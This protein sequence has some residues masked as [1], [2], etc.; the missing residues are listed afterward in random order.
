MEYGVPAFISPPELFGS[1]TITWILLGLFVYWAGV[2]ALRNANLLPSYVGTQGP[3]L[4]FHTKRGRAFLD[5][6]SGPKRFW[7]A[8]ANFG[9]G[10]SLVVMVAMFGFL[11]LAAIAALTS[12]QPATDVQQP[13]NVLVIPGV[14]DFLPLSAAPGI[15]FGLLVGLVVHEG[16][17]GLLCRVE[18]ID[19]NSMGVAM[20]AI[21]PIGAF[22]EPDHESSKDASRGGQTRMFAAGV[23]ANFAVTILV[24][25]LLFGPIAGSIAVAPGAAVGGIAPD[26]PAADAGIEPNDR[27]T[28]INGDPVEG[29]DDLEDRLEAADGEVIDVEVNDEETASVERSLLVTAAMDNGPTGLDIGDAVVA[30]NG[31]EVATENQ[32]YE[33]VGD[34]EVVTLTVSPDGEDELVER[35]V[36][37]GAAVTLVEDGPLESALGATEAPVVVTA[38]DGERTHTYSDLTSILGEREPGDEIAITGYVDDERIEETVTL[39]E[40]AQQAGNAF[41]GV[42]PNPGTSGLDLSAIGVQLYPAEEYL[43]MLGGSGEGSFGAVTD[44]FLGKIGLALLLPII[45]VVGMLPFNFAGFT[46]GVENFYEVQGSLAA[47]GDGTV[48]VIANLLFWTGWINVQLGFFN[49]IPA[50]PLDGGHILRTSTEAVVSRLP[51]EATRGMVRVVTTTVGLTMLASFLLMLFGPGLLAG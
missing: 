41:L 35:D 45:G 13:R 3:I 20:L 50:F 11:L 51:I 2:L 48:F 33:A 42:E 25:A 36:P 49:L 43:V 28:A 19:I 29:N 15:V 46:G 21:I 31:Q 22:V 24:F 30:V 38:V 8:W 32:F 40:H 4:T 26:S 1:E 34:N 47:L 18:D 23:T 9:I 6:L 37:I 16:G 27:I 44:S 7:R 17:H 12:P 14:N 5:W 39:D 10:I